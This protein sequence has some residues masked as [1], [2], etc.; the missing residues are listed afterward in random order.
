MTASIRA[1]GPD[2]CNLAI[3][4]SHV[5]GKAHIFNAEGPDIRLRR[6]AERFVKAAEKGEAWAIRELLDRIDGKV[7]QAMILQGDVE[8]PVRYV[9]VPRKA[10]NADEWLQM[11]TPTLASAG[12]RAGD[13]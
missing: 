9:E 7:P 8:Q 3:Q 10:A 5:C 1:G 6:I 13:R 11:Q 4:G 12:P 2:G